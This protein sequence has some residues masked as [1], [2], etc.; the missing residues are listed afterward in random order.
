VPQTFAN[1]D[2]TA[3]LVDE[4]NDI[5]QMKPV[6]RHVGFALRNEILRKKLTPAERYQPSALLQAKNMFFNFREGRGLARDRY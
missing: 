2:E 3:F 6:L 4:I 1:G 5:L